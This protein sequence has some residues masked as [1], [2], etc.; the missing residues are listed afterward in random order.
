MTLSTNY[1]IV[2]LSKGQEPKTKGERAAEPQ[3]WKIW[4][5]QEREEFTERKGIGREK[6]FANPIRMIG[7]RAVTFGKLR[8]KILIGQGQTITA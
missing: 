3:G 6:A 7:Q 4:Q 1:A 5:L 2:Y 8:L